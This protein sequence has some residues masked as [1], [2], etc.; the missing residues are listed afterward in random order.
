MAEGTFHAQHDRL[1]IAAATDRAA[2][3]PMTLARCGPCLVLHTDLAALA[4][5]IPLAAIPRRPRDYTLTQ[6]D[7]VRLRASGW[8]RLVDAFGTTRDAF[9]RPLAAGFLA[10][11]V[12]GLLLTTVPIGLPISGASTDA[13]PAVVM[14]LRQVEASAEPGDGTAPEIAGD[15]SIS[16]P[17]FVAPETAAID[18]VSPLMVVSGA[19]M[20]IGI[21][22]AGGRAFA[23]R[24]RSVR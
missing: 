22:L 8:R 3:F 4:R 13:A 14:D 20:G 21:V 12:V 7:A 23:M 6:G 10:L 5:A 24:R 18:G 15:P 2:A 11:G 9:S 16:E 17:R 1:A 19:F